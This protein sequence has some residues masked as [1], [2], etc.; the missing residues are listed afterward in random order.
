MNTNKIMAFFLANAIVASAISFNSTSISAS[1]ESS[2]IPSRNKITASLAEVV[3]RSSNEVLPVILWHN[4]AS[5]NEI[6]S[7]VEERIGFNLDNLEVDYPEPSEELMNELS[8]AANGEPSEYLHFLMERH[9]DLTASARA[10]EKERTDLYRQ[11][12]LSVLKELNLA[13][14]QQV[15]K[16][17]N[18]SPDRIGFMSSFAPMIICGMTVDEILQIA[19][20]DQINEIDYYSPLEIEECSINLGT[21]KAT[22]GIDKINNILNLNGSDVNIGIYETCTVSSQYYSMFDLNASQVSIVGTSFNPGDTHST[23]CAG[24][25]AG[26]NGVAPSA[27]IKSATCEFDW[28][29]FD[30]S[31]YS[32]AQLSNF[33]NL[34][35]DGVDVISISWGSGNDSNCYNYWSKYTDYVIANASQTVVCATG[36]NSSSYILNPSSSYNCIAVNGFVDT[37]DGQPQE[38]L[39]DYSY[40]HGSGCFKPDVIGPSLNNGTSTATPYIAGMIALMYQYK[41]SLA[42][43]PELTKA[44]LM[45]SCHRKC[46]KLL[47][48]NTISDLN[49]ETMAAGLTTREGAGIPDMYRMISI[50]SQHTYG[51]GVLNSGNNYARTINI[52]QPNYNSSN[53]NFSMAYLQTNVPSGSA[54]GTRDDYDLTITNNGSTFYS[55]LGNSSTEMIYKAL[56]TDPNYQVNIHKYSGNTLQVRYGYAWSTDKERYFNNYGEEGV[57][58]LKNYNSNFYLSRDTST[59]RAVQSSF[60][61]SMNFIWVLDCLSSSSTSYA[62]KNAN[63]LSNGLGLGS[64]IS[65]NNY[66]A[67]EGNNASVSNISVDYNSSTGTYTFKRIVNGSTYALGIY[68]QST[69]SGASANWMPYSANNASQKWYLETVNYRSGDANHDGAMTQMDTTIVQQH[70]TYIAPISN[71]LDMYLADVNKDNSI[72]VGDAV[73]ISQIIN[74]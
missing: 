1:Q 30:W 62:I 18:L 53:M 50:I 33:E 4:E 69:S 16:S 59:N 47:I 32:N 23:Y 42:A 12:R 24:I 6:E 27:H 43:F 55:N 9:M 68:S 58:Y 60:T 49:T 25:A 66:Y 52:L 44:I 65:T 48:G 7:L 73:L 39:N 19:E 3:N 34:I 31:D 46:S 26:S 10:E 63:I 14:S 22:V 38:L 29:S 2:S 57:F 51:N 54:S 41:P 20:N 13:A 64:L 36:N 67:Q 72:D 74:E 15:V 11:T 35:D 45:G 70:Y 28:Q 17:V 71:N 5:C 61:N 21:T 37:F 8:N 56:S 40:N